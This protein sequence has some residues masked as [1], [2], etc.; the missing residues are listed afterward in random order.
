MKANL[1]LTKQEIE[2]IYEALDHL[3]FET[4]RAS[5][6][7]HVDNLSDLKDHFSDKK[8]F[9]KNLLKRIKTCT[10]KINYLTSI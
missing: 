9:I 8:V 2:L 7:N 10:G 1:L 3:Y 5:Q 6:L 4:D